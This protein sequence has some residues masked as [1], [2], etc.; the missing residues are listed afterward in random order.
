MPA[1]R[2][3]RAA[4]ELL[5]GLVAGQRGEP[6]EPHVVRQPLGDA[7][8]QRAPGEGAV[9]DLPVEEVDLLVLRLEVE[10][11]ELLLELRLRGLLARDLGLAAGDL[12]PACRPSARGSS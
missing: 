1:R 4:L 7:V 12:R 9:L 8:E 2:G 5:L 11:V 10:A 3:E 6:V